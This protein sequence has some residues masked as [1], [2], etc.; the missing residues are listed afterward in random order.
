MKFAMV[1]MWLETDTMIQHMNKKSSY[2]IFF[3]FGDGSSIRYVEYWK[4]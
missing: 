4:L 3:C 1:V 2:P